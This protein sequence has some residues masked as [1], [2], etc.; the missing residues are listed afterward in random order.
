MMASD[1]SSDTSHG[2]MAIV[3]RSTER[4]AMRAST[5]NTMPIGG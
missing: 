2:S 4:L 5:N 3:V 1:T